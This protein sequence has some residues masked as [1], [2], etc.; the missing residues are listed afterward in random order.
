VISVVSCFFIA[1]MIWC[2]ISNILK[3]LVIL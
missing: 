2:I 1:L 3:C